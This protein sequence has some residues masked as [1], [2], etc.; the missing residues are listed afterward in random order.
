V[1]GD[2]NDYVHVRKINTVVANLIC[3][4][5]RLHEIIALADQY[6]MSEGTRLNYLANEETVGTGAA[7][8]QLQHLIAL[9]I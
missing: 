2:L 7:L 5:I 1:R 6:R 3:R 4:H 8:K 9:A